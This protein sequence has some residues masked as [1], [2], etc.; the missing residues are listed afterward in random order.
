[1]YRMS[2]DTI[3]PSDRQIFR[4]FALQNYPTIATRWEE[5]EIEFL[6]LVESEGK[7]IVGLLVMDQYDTDRVHIKLMVVD[8]MYRMT[9]LGTKMLTYVA[10]RYMNKRITLNVDFSK[11][12]LLGFYCVKGYAKLDDVS[13]EHKV[14]MLSLNHVNLIA[15][16]PLPANA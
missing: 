8:R 10:K 12:E 16:V 5:D 3:H 9:G 14:F 7:S 2:N 15:K 11:P 13:I 1:M 4:D 6:V